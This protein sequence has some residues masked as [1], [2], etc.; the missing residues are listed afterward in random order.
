MYFTATVTD[1]NYFIEPCFTIVLNLQ[2]YIYLK[3][4]LISN[5]TTIKHTLDVC[6]NLKMFLNIF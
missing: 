5:K 6:Y 4:I 3:L 2:F 1:S